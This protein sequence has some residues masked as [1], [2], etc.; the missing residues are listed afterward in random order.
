[1]AANT[2]TDQLVSD[3]DKLFDRDAPYEEQIAKATEIRDL[4]IARSD[5]L[6]VQTRDVMLSLGIFAS[7]LAAKCGS[8]METSRKRY[9]PTTKW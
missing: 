9:R 8:V 7:E 3:C 1:M 2:A 5:E 4:G 6:G